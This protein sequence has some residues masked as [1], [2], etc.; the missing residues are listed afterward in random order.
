MAKIDLNTVS[1][2][3]L[4]QAALNANFAAIEDEFQNKVLYRDNPNGEPNSMQTHLDMNGFNVINAGNAVE[5]G[6][7][8]SDHLTFLQAGT[9]AVSRTLTSKMRDVVSVKDFGAVGDG[10][11]D[12]TTAVSATSAQPKAFLPAGT[13]DTTYVNS[14]L[15]PGSW[16]G[17][18]QIADASNRKLPP[19]FANASSAPSSVGSATSLLT[20]FNG[21][22]S[23]CQLPIGHYIQGATTLTQPTTGY[24]YQ[25]ESYPHYTYLYNSSGW[26]QS[27]SGNDG[28]TA[29]C[30]Y[31]TKVDNYGQGDC[32]AYNASAFVTGTRAGS[33]NFLANPAASLFNGDM[34]A[35]QDGV[36]LNP[37]ETFLTDIGYDVAGV[38]LVNNFNRTNATGAKSVVW[39]GYRAQNVGTQPCDSFLSATGKWQVG[40]DFAMSTTDFGA[41]KAAISL[42]ENDRI[43][44]NS[45]ATA[46][47]NLE[48]NWRTTV[49]GTSW[50]TLDSS[51]GDL[52]FANNSATQ[53]AVANT[54]SSV[55]YFRVFG[56]ATGAIPQLRA[57]GS[58]TNISVGYV[59]KGTG[60]H[61]FYSGSVVQFAI[62]GNQ[63][64]AV[65][66]FLASG[67]ATGTGP[68]LTATGS[69]TNIDARI[70]AKGT[71][72]VDLHTPT[73]GSAGAASGYMTIKVSGT[74][75]KVPLYA[76]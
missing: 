5:V 10:V 72:V 2:G 60:F 22:L 12:D 71:G 21:D 9:G 28:R 24:Y 3:Y 66:Y 52:L 25:A 45:T 42:K 40:L 63:T 73:A 53:F 29:A 7:V 26:N 31:R 23:K 48:A 56:A 57:G 16:Q 32:V 18:G 50:M 70:I 69:D 75:Y 49:F 36:Y 67:F 1:S 33:T 17:I 8:D 61:F 43:Y 46:S 74:S 76:L 27:T 62:N 65:N 6:L 44:F 47:G 41:N 15:V 38:G 34:T 37:Y 35:G 51:S 4:S 68:S 58:D 13:Y 19:W 14:S 30:A 11:T 39:L 59:S 20:A 55:N 64:S 54:A